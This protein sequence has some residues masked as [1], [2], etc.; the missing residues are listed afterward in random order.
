MG[1]GTE[2]RRDFLRQEANFSMA[3]EWFASWSAETRLRLAT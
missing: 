3:I 2:L 1:A